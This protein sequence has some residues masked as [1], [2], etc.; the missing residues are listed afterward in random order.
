[1]QVTEVRPDVTLV[2]R[3]VVSAG[4]YDYTFDW[5]FKTAGSIKCV[6]CSNDH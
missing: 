5:E 3:T 2:V 1:M 6:V 4:N